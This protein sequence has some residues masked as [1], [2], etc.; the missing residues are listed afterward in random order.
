MDRYVGNAER[1]AGKNK[2]S[3]GN[4]LLNSIFALDAEKINCT[5]EKSD[6]QSVSRKQGN[7]LLVTVRGK[8]SCKERSIERGRKRM[9]ANVFTVISDRRNLGISHAYT[10]E[11]GE[12]DTGRKME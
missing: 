5:Q 6:A 2:D 3:V 8:T 10:A 11:Q 4:R 12:E 9:T 7:T 1:N